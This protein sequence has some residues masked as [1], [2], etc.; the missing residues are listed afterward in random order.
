MLSLFTK[1]GQKPILNTTNYYTKYAYDGTQGLSFD[2]S[3][4]DPIFSLIHNESVMI[5][6]ENRYLVKG[7][8]KRAQYATITCQLDM[9]EWKQHEPYLD[10]STMAIFQSKTLLEVLDTVKPDGWEIRNAGIR[11]IRRTI[12]LQQASAYDVLMG[13]QEVYGVVYEI[14]VLEKYIYVIDPEQVT[15]KNIYISPQLNL[16][17]YS[18]TGDSSTFYTRLSAYGKRDE[19]TGEY[20][21]FADINGGKSYVEN[22]EY[23]GKAQPVWAIWIDERYTVPEN[24]LT[25][26]QTKLKTMCMPM[27]SFDITIND[28]AL[29]TDKYKFLKLGMYDIVHVLLDETTVIVEKVIEYQK[30]HNTPEKNKVTLSSE[31]QMITSRIDKVESILGDD[32]EKLEEN[33]LQHAQEAAADLIKQFA[34]KGH[35]YETENETY[36]L[37]KLPKEEAQYV[38]RMNLGGI[39]FSTTG[40]QGPYTTAWTIDGKFNADFIATGTL[41]A[42]TID[43]VNIIGG[44]I[45]GDT[46]DFDLDNGIIKFGTRDDDG[47]ISDPVL[48]FDRDRL[49]IKPLEEITQKVEDIENTKMYR[50]VIVSDNGSVFKNGL[51]DTNLHAIVYSWDDDVTDQ[52]DDNQFI[53]TRVSADE[54]SDQA[55]N[56]AHAGGTKSIHVTAEDVYVRATFYCDLIDTTTRMSLL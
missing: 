11:S 12:E 47:E 14:H 31:P 24:L 19:E 22:N 26:A 16:Q 30:Y 8:N 29:Q 23:A 34:T 33:F 38:M 28:L 35:R 6:E 36:F 53:W 25:D 50:L 10:T 3:S 56:T 7:I 13:C 21:T 51:I 27:M 9:D 44:M 17:E 46:F 5:N 49:I 41:R 2:L 55:W 20:M 45:S 18:M 39:A 42:I 1:D 40:W 48:Y 4:S 52:L 15:D 54:E 37:D 43:A 32:G